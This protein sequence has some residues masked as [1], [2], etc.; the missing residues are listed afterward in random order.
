MK[1][2]RDHA[3]ASAED[4]SAASADAGT[5][6]QREFAVKVGHCAHTIS[7][8]FFLNTCYRTQNNNINFRPDRMSCN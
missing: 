6:Q 8:G 1:Q 2:Q 5:P 4:A 3:I 7:R